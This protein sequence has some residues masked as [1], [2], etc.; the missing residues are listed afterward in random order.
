[1]QSADEGEEAGVSNTTVDEEFTPAGFFQEEGSS[2]TDDGRKT[3]EAKR[4][5]GDGCKVQAGLST[6]N[7]STFFCISANPQ[8]VKSVGQEGSAGELGTT[9]ELRRQRSSLT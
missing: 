5:I 6:W 9:E 7:V 2:D 3:E 1:M 8:E 4:N